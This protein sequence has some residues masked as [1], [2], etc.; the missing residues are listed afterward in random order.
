MSQSID[1]FYN[2]YTLKLPIFKIISFIKRDFKLA[3]SYRLDFFFRIWGIF[4]QVILFY[5]ISKIFGPSTSTHLL[6][7]NADYFTFVIIGIAFSRYILYGIVSFS[8]A[9]SEQQMLGTLE[10]M[11]ITGTS[12]FTIILASSVWGF[13]YT[14][15]EV[16]VYFLFGIIIFGME[17]NLNSMFAILIILLLTIITSCSIGIISASF[18]M[19]FKRGDPIS[20]L[21]ISFSMLFGGV[22]FP[23]AVMPEWLQKVSY[24]LPIYYSLNA[25]RHALLQE[26]TF[27]ELIPD[28]MALIFFSIILLPLSLLI[29]NY[30]VKKAKVDGSLTQY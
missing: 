2:G 5:Y 24:L 10:A 25:T 13:I 28:I 19:V 8:K 18:I 12:L 29:F 14:T 15:F 11:L 30:A 6:P 3:I 16:L 22:F 9:V 7:Y 26:Y 21:S 4:F 1:A 23:I 27:L 17:I 20:W